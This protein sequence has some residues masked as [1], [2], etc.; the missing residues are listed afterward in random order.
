MPDAR[1]IATDG[2]FRI[3][4]VEEGERVTYTL[5]K[6]DGFD[7]LGVDRW[8]NLS[9]SIGGTGITRQLYTWII[10]H[11]VACAAMKEQSE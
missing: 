5:E 11:A 7:A 1:I 10:K 2:E 4:R 6:H 9:D 8:K 3:V